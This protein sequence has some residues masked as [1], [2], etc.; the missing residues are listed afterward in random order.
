MVNCALHYVGVS[1]VVE[2]DVNKQRYDHENNNK[3][4]PFV[5]FFGTSII[6]FQNEARLPSF[7]KQT[8]SKA[9]DK[10]YQHQNRHACSDYFQHVLVYKI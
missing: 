10:K 2:F 1:L 9:P 7:N 6:T 5:Q 3:R 4:D 8:T